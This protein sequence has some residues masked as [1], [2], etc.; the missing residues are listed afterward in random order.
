LH[1]IADLSPPV[2]VTTEAKSKDSLKLRLGS[3]LSGK[4]NV[5]FW[6]PSNVKNLQ[7]VIE[8]NGATQKRQL[9]PDQWGRFVLEGVQTPSTLTVEW[10]E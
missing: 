10:S 7:A 4:V 8:Q 9:A 2:E 1:P 5:R 3:T 6:L